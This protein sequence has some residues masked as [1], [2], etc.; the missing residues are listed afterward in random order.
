[1]AASKTQFLPAQE[2][3]ALT[4]RIVSTATKHNTSWA[5]PQVAHLHLALGDPRL[6]AHKLQAAMEAAHAF[7]IPQGTR[8]GCI[9]QNR[10]STAFTRLPEMQA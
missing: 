9:E 1:M 3:E 4:R 6:P 7:L 8:Y 10:A 5:A 2:R